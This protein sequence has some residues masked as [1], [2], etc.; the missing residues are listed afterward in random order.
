MEINAV[1]VLKFLPEGNQ[2]DL[3]EK[4]TKKVFKRVRKTLILKNN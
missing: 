3:S 1:E 2:R 4:G